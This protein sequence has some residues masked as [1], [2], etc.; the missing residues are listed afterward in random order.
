MIGSANWAILVPNG[1]ALSTTNQRGWNMRLSVITTLSASVLLFSLSAHAGTFPE[2]EEQKY[3]EQCLNLYKENNLDEKVAEN[4]CKCNIYALKSKFSSAE[5][6]ELTG[7]NRVD[8]KLAMRAM[9]AIQEKC[10]VRK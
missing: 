3:L 6:A 2:G 10:A 7:K 8:P 1:V 9:A 4:H 5:I